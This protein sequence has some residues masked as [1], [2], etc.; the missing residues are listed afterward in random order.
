MYQWALLPQVYIFAK[1]E[2]VT[3]RN[4]ILKIT[5]S[6]NNVV[7][8]SM[9]LINPSRTLLRFEKVKITDLE[10]ATY[11]TTTSTNNVTLKTNPQT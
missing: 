8:V 7:L 9:N 3:I 1:I 6:A 5:T 11:K 10:N 4:S 2:K